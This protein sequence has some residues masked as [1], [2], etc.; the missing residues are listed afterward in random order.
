MWCGLAPGL[1][2]LILARGL[3]GVGGA[4]LIPGSL[5]LVSEAF[6]PERRGRAI[7]TWSAFTSITAAIGPLLG[8]WLVEHASWR[9]AFFLNAPLAVAVVVLALLHVPGSRRDRGV[10]SLDWPGAVLATVGLGGVVFA[11][12]AVNFG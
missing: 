12:M 1:G 2:Q 8:G 5:A 9:W 3:Q 4:M 11:L 7:G 10:P 6:P